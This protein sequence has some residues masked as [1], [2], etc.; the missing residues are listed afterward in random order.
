MGRLAMK[1]IQFVL[2]MVFVSSAALVNV[3]CQGCHRPPLRG[4]VMPT[5]TPQDPGNNVNCA[6]T[7][8]I[9]GDPG[10]QVSLLSVCVPSAAQNDPAAFCQNDVARYVLGINEQMALDSVAGGILPM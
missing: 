9:Q 7:T 8:S 3:A 5:V 6:C 10:Q 2:L 4:K 1:R